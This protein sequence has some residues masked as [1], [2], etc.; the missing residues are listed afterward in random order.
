MRKSQRFHL[1]AFGAA[2]VVFASILLASCFGEPAARRGV[3]GQA[4]INVRSLM[5]QTAGDSGDVSGLRVVITLVTPTS[6]REVATKIWGRDVINASDKDSTLV[7]T[8][9]FPYSSA[10]DKFE[11]SVQAFNT[12]GDT[13]YRAGPSAFTARDASSTT[14]TATVT[15]PAVYVGPGATA[16][17]LRISPRSLALT[18]GQNQSAT[19]TLVDA[20]GNA[21]TTTGVQWYSLDPSIGFVQN[22]GVGTVTGGN[23][24]GTGRLV[25][26]WDPKKLDDTIPITN[27]VRV[28]QLS[29]PQGNN[30]SARV[31][32]QFSLPITV[33]ARSAAGFGVGGVTISFAV[34]QGGGSVSKAS[35][36][37][38]LPDGIVTVTWIAGPTVG[39]QALTASVAGGPS[40]V[41]NGTATA[42]A[43]SA[44]QS[45]VSVLPTAIAANGDPA[46]VTATV[47]DAAGNPLSNT[48]VNFSGTGTA[49]FT[50]NSATTNASGV[51]TTQVRATAA[52]TITISASVGSDF[53]GSTT[54]AVG[55]LSG[56]PTSISIVS[57]DNQTVHIGQ[58]FPLS[59]VVVV[60]NAAGGTVSG[61]L[62]DWG[63]AVGDGRKVTDANGLSSAIYYLPLGWTA[64]PGTVSVVLTGTGQVATFHYTAVP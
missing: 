62:V 26:H 4:L 16:V 63:T 39:P 41:I 45:S 20:Q 6:R 50:S 18:E 14:G 43:P 59:L 2:L 34:T 27:S 3:T 7:L 5:S 24:P 36:V 56:T 53:V 8:M 21:V 25:A 17:K 31:G 29:V 9:T 54:L 23:Q 13:L 48:V 11:L 1:R 64:G 49:V 58:N 32:T 60:R 35:G 30:Q 61:A 57:G 42:G 51:A 19:A 47:R 10:D 55:S 44:S 52:G 33:Q 37:T 15:V 46:T 12:H 40:I 28:A 22:N 38:G